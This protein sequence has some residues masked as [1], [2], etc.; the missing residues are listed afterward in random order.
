MA[1]VVIVGG[2]LKLATIDEIYEM[3]H[4]LDTI[5]YL[6]CADIYKLL[7]LASALKATLN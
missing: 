4:V 1:I 2:D 7:Y 6:H 5:S 3:N